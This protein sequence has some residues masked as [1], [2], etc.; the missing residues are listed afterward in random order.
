MTNDPHIPMS[1]KEL[2]Q[3]RIHE[4]VKLPERPAPFDFAAGYS[5][6]VPQKTIAYGEPEMATYLGQVEW[7]WDPMHC[8]LEAYYLQQD[9]DYWVLW[10]RYWSDNDG[11]WGWIIV[12]CVATKGVSE[13][14]AAVHLLIEFW[15]QETKE[16]SLDHFHWINKAEYLSVAQLAAIGRAVWEQ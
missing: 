14:Q 15:K 8:R 13:E 2:P 3:Q 4:V 9:R 7:A 6:N 5:C 11:D 16:S 10:A 1:P 12:A